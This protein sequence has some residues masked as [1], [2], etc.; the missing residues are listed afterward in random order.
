[1][2]KNNNARTTTQVALQIA[3]KEMNQ[4]PMTINVKFC[5]RCD[6]S[7]YELGRKTRNDRFYD[8]WSFL[9]ND[10]RTCDDSRG[11]HT[12]RYRALPW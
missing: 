5:A 6:C 10:I 4:Q 11:I 8:K 1:M 7:N 12:A 3:M 9:N 2:S